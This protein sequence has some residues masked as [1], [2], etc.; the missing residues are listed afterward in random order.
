MLA[1]RTIVRT[2]SQAMR[3]DIEF[4]ADG[5]TL[6]GWLYTPETGSAP[7]P[8]IVMAHGFSGVKEMG[9]DDYAEVFAEAGLAVIAYDNRNL[10][11]SD[12]EPRF[13]IDPNAQMRDYG[14]A[15]TYAASQSVVDEIRVGVWGT[16]YTGGLVLIAAAIDR[17]VRCVVSQVPYLHGL[18]TMEQV[19]PLEGIKHVYRMIDEERTS[20]AA[21]NPPNYIPVYTDD[22]SKPETSA[23]RLTAAFFDTFVAKGVAWENRFTIRSLELRLEYDAVSFIDRVSPTPLLMIVATDDNITPTAIALRAYERALAPKKLV[24]IEGHHYRAYLDAFDESSGAA[25]EWFVEHL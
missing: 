6:R 11:A 23:A 24:M 13:E 12:G 7:Y 14:H 2:I 20:R 16:S 3:T 10:G 19:T 1:G 8:T 9:L 21:G 22:P 17:R 4:D 18:E 5:T 25:R 15:I